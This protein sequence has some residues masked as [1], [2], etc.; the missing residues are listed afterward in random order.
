MTHPIYMIHET[1]GRVCLRCSTYVELV[2]N[3]KQLRF[4][5]VMSYIYIGIR[6]GIEQFGTLQG[7]AN[8][9]GELVT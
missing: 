9:L 1:P 3:L 6:F 2:H 7:C 8:V 5:L 4:F